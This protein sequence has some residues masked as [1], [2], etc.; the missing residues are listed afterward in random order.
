M[1]ITKENYDEY[2][3]TCWH[4]EFCESCKYCHECH[5]INKNYKN[6]PP[7]CDFKDNE[8]LEMYDE[9]KSGVRI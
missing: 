5:G 3:H 6:Y 9:I 4:K 2:G 1:N 8:Y 7:L